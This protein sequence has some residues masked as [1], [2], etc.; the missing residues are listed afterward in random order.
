MGGDALH[1]FANSILTAVQFAYDIVI[2]LRRLEIEVGCKELV[3]LL[4]MKGP[5]MGPAGVLVAERSFTS[6]D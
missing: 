2:G 6:R 1:G 5:C 4:Q 3:G